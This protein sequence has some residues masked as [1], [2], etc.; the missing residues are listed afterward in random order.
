MFGAETPEAGLEVWRT[1]GT[2]AGTELLRD[3]VPGTGSSR[4]ANFLTVGDKVYFAAN[5][6]V[7]A[8][9]WVSDGT[10]GERRSNPHARHPLHR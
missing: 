3:I 1:D 6:G 4:A 5:I 10:A 9:L 2:S 8:Q 7:T